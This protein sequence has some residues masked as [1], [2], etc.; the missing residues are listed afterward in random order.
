MNDDAKTWVAKFIPKGFSP[1][2]KPATLDI[3]PEGEHM[4]DLIVVMLVYIEKLRRDHHN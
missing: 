2:A 1:R 3:S 4:V